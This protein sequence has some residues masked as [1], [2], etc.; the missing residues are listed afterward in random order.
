M[1]ILGDNI[2]YGVGLGQ[3]IRR[4]IPQSGSH[5]F[6]YE[7]ADPSQYGILYFDNNGKAI[8]I[9]EKPS[10][11]DSNKAVTGL[12]FFD[13]N[14]AEI[15]KTISPSKRGELEITSV[16]EVYLERQEL[17]VTQLSRGTAWLDTGQVDSLH[18]ASSF[19]RVIEERTGL[20]VACLEEIALTMNLIS[21]EEFSLASEKYGNSEYGKY[22]KNI[23]KRMMKN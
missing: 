11:S 15:A 4:A 12:Y 5:I 9:K 17:S 20:K 16:I 3:D 2:F 19:I 23:K 10:S 14:V 13:S 8:A 18:D 21:I 7:V 1:M 6:T 22:L